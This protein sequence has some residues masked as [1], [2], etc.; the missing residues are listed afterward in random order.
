MRSLARFMRVAADLLGY[1][2]RVA[3]PRW[4]DDVA[5]ELLERE[6]EYAANHARMTLHVP[7]G[8]YWMR[9][10]DA[11]DPEDRGWIVCQVVDG[12]TWCPGSDMEGMPPTVLGPRVCPPEEA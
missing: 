10:P 12:Y 2:L 1:E 7:D 11:H 8:F 5:L 9:W 4:N 3:S 6:L